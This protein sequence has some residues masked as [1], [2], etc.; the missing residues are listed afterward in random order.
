MR[1]DTERP[2]QIGK[3]ATVKVSLVMEYTVDVEMPVDGDPGE[4]A[5]FELFALERYDD[6]DEKVVLNS[7]ILEEELLYEDERDEE[8]WPDYV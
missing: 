4:Q 7:E 3:K 8:D 2:M 6:Y 5:D 1:S